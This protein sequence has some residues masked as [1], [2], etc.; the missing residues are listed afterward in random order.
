MAEPALR[1]RGATIQGITA[2]GTYGPK[3]EYD[4]S[5]SKISMYTSSVTK[6]FILDLSNE[7]LSYLSSATPLTIFNM[8]TSIFVMPNDI[9]LNTGTDTGVTR[10]LAFE[11]GL[12]GSPSTQNVIRLR[13][14]SL[15]GGGGILDQ[16]IRQYYNGVYYC[17]SFQDGTRERL[18][19]PIGSDPIG[20]YDSFLVY[21]STG[22]IVP[23]A[24]VY[25]DSRVDS[26]AY[27]PADAGIKVGSFTTTNRSL[28]ASGTVNLNGSDYCEYMTKSSSFT[29]GKGDIA[30]I[31]IS[32]QLTN[33]FSEAIT[34]GIKSTNPCLVGGDTWFSDLP[35][36]PKYYPQDPVNVSEYSTHIGELAIWEELYETK[37]TAVDRIAFSG[38]VP[39]NISTESVASGDYIL[40]SAGPDDT[41]IATTVSS[42]NITFNEYKLA[43]GRVINIL[44]PTKA[45]C[46][47]IM[48]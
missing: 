18:N 25:M 39:V 1:I 31:D 46:I 9:L 26:L 19:I 6:G 45:L 23:N 12:N 14:R 8:S 36:K 32:G 38:Q 11:A 27:N 42:S 4:I 24:A 20:V 35:N 48:H 5:A 40:P 44:S 22:G 30:G 3:L 33:K 41:I 13:F 7:S 17:L 16:S 47:V 34:F 28:N 37:R 29:I 2:E 21:Q 15:A 43:V 10:N